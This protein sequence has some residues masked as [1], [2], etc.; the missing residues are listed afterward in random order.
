M[1]KSTKNRPKIK[2]RNGVEL[3]SNCERHAV[4]VRESAAN[5]ANAFSSRIARLSGAVRRAEERM[6][7]MEETLAECL[8]AGL[9]NPVMRVD[10][11]GVIVISGVPLEGE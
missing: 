2:L 7:K 9:Q 10:S 6:A 1:Y 8:I 5:I 11:A 4:R 3:R